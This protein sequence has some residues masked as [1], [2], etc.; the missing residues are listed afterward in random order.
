MCTTLVL[1]FMVV[2][3]T[4][5]GTQLITDL[6]C[7]YVHASGPNI[8][9]DRTYICLIMILIKVDTHALGLFVVC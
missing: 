4:S 9:W 8:P 1:V 2:D 5:H 7:A 6:D 3:P